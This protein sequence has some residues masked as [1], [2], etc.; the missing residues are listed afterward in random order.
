VLIDWFTVAAQIVNFI[1][2]VALL[3][4]FLY[5]PLIAAIDAREQSIAQ[6]VS[7]AA[8]KEQ[9]ANARLEQLNKEAVESER[10]KSSVL[11][12]AR[13]DADR[14]RGEILTKARDDVKALE[15]HWHHELEREK[16]A[17]LSDVRRRAATGILEVTRRALRDLASADV[18]GCAVSCFLEKLRT[19]DPALLRSVTSGEL[20][21][22]SHEPLSSQARREVQSAVDN[23]LGVPVPIRFECAEA[24]AWGVELRGN[25]QRIGWT[26]DIYLD[27]LEDRLQVALE[28]AAAASYPVTTT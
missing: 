16:D 12:A 15:T 2:L 8:A 18:Q 22:V 19:L 17:F 24:M 11:A 7:E 10:Q 14:Q 6:R 5:G 26:P 28:S 3:K 21:V 9:T 20:T 27:S 13:E 1:I 25:G 23:Q 4:R